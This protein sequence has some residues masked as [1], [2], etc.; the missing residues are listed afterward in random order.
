VTCLRATHRQ[1]LRV[2]NK[3]LAR[4]TPCEVFKVAFIRITTLPLRNNSGRWCEQDAERRRAYGPKGLWLH[5]QPTLVIV[6]GRVNRT[7]TGTENLLRRSDE[8]G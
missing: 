3:E 5:G 2:S 1:T 6:T 7:R 4:M 8:N